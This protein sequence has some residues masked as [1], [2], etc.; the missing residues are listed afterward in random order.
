MLAGFNDNIRYKGVLFHVQT[1]DG[2]E[3]R[4]QIV[5]QLFMGGAVL[6]TRKT[7]YADVIRTDQVREVVLAVMKEQHLEMLRRL[8]RGEFDGRAFPHG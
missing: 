1:E 8:E 5:T 3:K 2:G 7:S 6:C 4:P